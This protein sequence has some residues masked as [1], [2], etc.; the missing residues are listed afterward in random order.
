M[1]T[2]QNKKR[3]GRT[4]PIP[5]ERTVTTLTDG[6]D[7]PFL[8][9]ASAGFMTSPFLGSPFA[10]FPMAHTDHTQQFLPTPQMVLPPGEDDL[11]ILEKL[12]DMIKN[13]QHEF[14]RAV[15]QPRALASLYLGPNA[16][17]HGQ[18]QPQDGPMSPGDQ[19]RT[20]PPRIHNKDRS[21]AVNTSVNNSSSDRFVTR[22]KTKQKR[23]LAQDRHQQLRQAR[24]KRGRSATDLALMRRLRPLFET[25]A[26]RRG[27]ETEIGM[28]AIETGNA[29]E[30]IVFAMSGGCLMCAGRLLSNGTTSLRMTGT[31]HRLVAH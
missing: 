30:I 22:R 20:R 18:A 13:G 25:A 6:P 2:R 8:H 15:P 10:G 19:N 11:E 21:I 9:E 7:T 23:I 5:R 17:A 12:K 27:I 3:K 31:R 29:T 28:R 26:L 24:L 1:S 4:L 16:P 14:Y